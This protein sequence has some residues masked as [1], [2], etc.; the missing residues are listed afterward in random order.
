MKIGIDASRI[1]FK[2][3][4][5]IENYSTQLLHWFKKLDGQ[6]S[7]NE[8]SNTEYI[9]Y[10]QKKSGEEFFDLPNNF[11]LKK[12]YFPFFWTQLRLAWNLL[13]AKEKPDTFF[14][15]SNSIPFFFLI[16]N[17]SVKKVATIHDVAFKYFPQSYSF[18]G[19][20]YLNLS[21]Y[22]SIKFCERIITI[23]NSTKNDLIKLYNC[24]PKKISVTY[25]GFD[26]PCDMGIEWEEGKWQEIQKK[27]NI[28]KPFLIYVG[29]LENKKNIT[30]LIKSYYEVLS[31]GAD[32]QLVLVGKRGLGW[33]E[34]EEIIK[35]YN[36]QDRIVVTGYTKEW[37]RDI[38]LKKAKALVFVSKY[39]G[40]GL[41]V[42]EAFN[43]GT[44]VVAS[45]IPVFQ[46]LF[47]SSCVLVDPENPKEIAD[48]TMKL[49]KSP[50]RQE[51][52][53]KHGRELLK[54]YTWEKCARE[55]LEIIKSL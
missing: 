43:A 31:S 8:L 28:E 21:V 9:L 20:F 14:V 1:N 19:R 38:L 45:E 39:E 44:P 12:M 46:E 35:K 24:D 36:L 27:Y 53:V 10:A 48:A 26:A 7:G 22:F 34:A 47:S 15:P 25:L 23:S 16:F 42:L 4:T 17:K 11:H 37:E 55:T 30:N 33:E 6:Y 50:G 32:L 52:L 5:G 13:F 18:I 51:T 49:L 2:I 41:P 54:N 40:F 3:K 29:R